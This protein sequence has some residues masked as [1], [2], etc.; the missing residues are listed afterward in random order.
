MP[1]LLA[2]GAHI[3]FIGIC[4]TAMAN[5]AASLAGDGF[6]VTGSDSGA[7]PPMSTLLAERG[8]AVMEGYSA[9]N[10]PEPPALT[11]VGNAVSRGNPEVERVLDEDYPY[12]ALAAFIGEHFLPGRTPVVVTGTHCKTTTTALTTWL[13]LEGGLNP[14]WLIGGVPVG[15][16]SGFQVN[17]GMPFVLEGDEYDTAFFDKRP[18]FIHYRPKVLILN[19]LEYDHADIY[20]DMGRLRE[21]FSHLIRLVPG[22]GLIIANADD[23][24][25]MKLV[26]DAYTPVQR[27]S[28]MGADAEWQGEE[29]NGRVRIT[30]P[31][32][33]EVETEHSLIG[34]HQGWNL[35]AAIAAASAM[36]VDAKGI[37]EATASFRGVRRRGELRGEAR[38]IKVYDD[39]AHHPTAIKSTLEGFRDAF[40]GRRIIA[41]VEPRSNTMRRP[42]FHKPLAEAFD[43][44][45]RLFIHEVH[46]PQKCGAEGVLDVAELAANVSAR[47]TKATRHPDAG[48]ILAS[49]SGELLE[50]DIVVILSNGGFEGIHER[51]L[52]LLE[53]P[54]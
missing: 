24:E 9:E 16:A 26:K 18:K 45:D 44:A 7:Y 23:E 22:N 4:G 42:V 43:S 34:R 20:P 38:G 13:L 2:P 46:N 14:S 37:A 5:V 40:A 35:L 39:F 31:G 51:L 49:L 11:I 1:H 17:G 36:G 41:V 30:G 53:E 47:G 54:V 29:A 15:L 19:N 32:N 27:Y 48:A 6:N 28:L 12:T 21:V 3:H 10:I 50:G 33:F 8:I 52:A 25:V